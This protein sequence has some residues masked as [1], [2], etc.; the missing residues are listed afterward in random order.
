MLYLLE[1]N[2]LVAAFVFAGAGL[3]M[4]GLFAWQEA[5]AYAAARRRM[6]QRIRGGSP[7]NVP[8]HHHSR[9]PASRFREF[10]REFA[11]GSRAD[12]QNVSFTDNWA[13][14]GSPTP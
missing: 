11:K 2:A 10:F 13:C 6:Y 14:R 8:T 4:L 1:V 3:I 12:R 5:K 7:E 9:D